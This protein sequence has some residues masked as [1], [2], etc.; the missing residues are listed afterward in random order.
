MKTTQL[1]VM[2]AA[3]T[4]S[5][6]CSALRTPLGKSADEEA[7]SASAI[8]RN[9]DQSGPHVKVEFHDDDEKPKLAILAVTPDKPVYVSEA[10]RTV[11]AKKQFSRFTAEVFRTNG[12][13]YERMIVKMDDG[14]VVPLYDYALHPGDR[15]I[16]ARDSSNALDDMLSAQGGS[17]NVF[18]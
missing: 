14:K 2:L 18:R 1:C 16:V 9:A 13:R 15:L 12:G 8:A 5:V 3:L 4:L 7:P 10:L 17:L 11:K 6:G